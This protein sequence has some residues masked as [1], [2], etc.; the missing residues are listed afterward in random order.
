MAVRA[1]R[2]ETLSK[3]ES[4]RDDIEE[5]KD[6]EEGEIAPSPH[7]PSLKDL[8]SLGD[9]FIQQAGIFVGARQTKR[10]RTGARGSFDSPP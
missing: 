2:K 3:P 7:S 5:D 6:V 8:P 9:L 4:S 10:P 1:Q